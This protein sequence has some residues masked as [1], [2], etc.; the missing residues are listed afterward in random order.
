K[1]DDAGIVNTLALLNGKELR[2]QNAQLQWSDKVHDS[3][4][5]FYKN[6]NMSVQIDSPNYYLNIETEVPK[7]IGNKVQLIAE[8]ALNESDWLSKIYIKAKDIKPQS[9]MRYIDVSGFSVSGK[10]NTELWFDLKNLQLQNIAGEFRV[11]NVKAS[12][13]NGAVRKVWASKNIS[14]VFQVR[15]F[16]DEWDI[17]VDKLNMHL[18]KNKWEDVYFSLKYREG[19]NSLDAHCD[20]LDL[21]DLGQL[22]K[23][24]PLDKALITTLNSIDPKGELGKIEL[25]V[26][27][28][29]K[30]NNWLLKTSFNNLGITVPGEKIRLDGVS[31]ELGIDNNNGQIKLE[32]Q[33]VVINS[34]FFNKPLLLSQLTAAIEIQKTKDGFIFVSDSILSKIDAVEIQSRIRYELGKDDFLDL[35]VNFDGAD[36]LWFN[37]HR[38][39]ELFGKGVAKWL[40]GAIVAGDFNNAGF[41]FRGLIKD[42]PFRGNEGVIQSVV[43]VEEGVLKYQPDWPAITNLDARFVLDNEEIVIGQASGRVNHSLI[44]NSVTTINLA[45]DPHVVV[46]LDVNTNADDVNGF[47]IATPLKQDYLDLVKYVKIDGK[48]KTSLNIDIP[49]KSDQD[50]DVSGNVILN[51]NN[52]RVNDLGY[53]VK[54]INGLVDFKNELISSKDLTGIFNENKVTAILKTSKIRSGTKTFLDAR[55]KSDVASLVPVGVNVKSL[56]NKKADWVLALDFNHSSVPSGELMAVDLKSDLSGL[57]SNLPEPFSKKQNKHADF[58]LGFKV[59]DA[60]SSLLVHYDD[61][62]NLSM[63]WNDGFEKVR[64]DIRIMSGSLKALN[65]GVNITAKLK[66][67]NAKEW[68]AIVLPLFESSKSGES[69]AV[70]MN[71]DFDVNLLQYGSYKLNKMRLKAKLRDDDWSLNVSSNELVGSIEISEYFNNEKPLVMNFK[72]L[73][74]SSLLNFEESKGTQKNKTLLLSPEDVPP[75]KIQAKNFTYKDYSFS[76]MNLVTSRTSYGMTVHALDVK[77]ENLSLKAKGNWFSKKDTTDNS[78]FRIEIES[79]DVGHMLSFYDFTESIEDGKGRAVVD[80]QWA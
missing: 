35:Q 33:G 51:N 21:L 8:V 70:N 27:N 68:Q 77:G 57:E 58:K 79:D 45:G 5:Q 48:L 71:L 16:N 66:S 72:K 76:S 75:L 10:L 12:T 52:L 44:T 62:L 49:L 43:D 37:R 69:P 11:Q 36:A 29:K 74:L 15:R 56:F 19:D 7:N 14:S 60:S 65:D 40:S 20:Y 3:R 31:G 2:L 22:I 26:D 47:F 1:D 6:I 61:K 17:V 9:L 38:T 42:F 53:K 73:D 28:W 63:R 23:S 4:V 25:H 46:L 80:W 50:V 39:D 55:L 54:N 78:N 67:L 13:K 41:M 64:S 59:F 24:L 34:R 30:P 32:S 18:D